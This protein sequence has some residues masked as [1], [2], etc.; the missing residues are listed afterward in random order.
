MGIIA[1]GGLLGVYQ[2][3]EVVDLKK[4]TIH[5]EKPTLELALRFLKEAPILG[6]HD[7]EECLFFENPEYFKINKVHKF[8]KITPYYLLSDKRENSGLTFSNLISFNLYLYLKDNGYSDKTI[9]KV[10]P[11]YIKAVLNPSLELILFYLKRLSL[12]GLVVHHFPINLINQEYR[13]SHPFTGYSVKRDM[14][15][16]E[17]K[18][19]IIKA[20]DNI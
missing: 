12:K 9:L 18:L 7:Y 16:L 1:D 17:N 20:I 8:S 13:G 19:K 5:V 6:I 3:Q 14:N 10:N 15:L 2:T 4:E 11:Y